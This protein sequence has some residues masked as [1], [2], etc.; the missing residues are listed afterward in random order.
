MTKSIDPSEPTAAEGGSV[1]DL[2]TPVVADAD[3]SADAEITDD[4]EA[5]DLPDAG[6]IAPPRK[7]RHVFAYVLVPLVVMIMA[8]VLGYLRYQE[9]SLQAAQTAAITSVQA[10]T[11]GTVDLL[12]YRPDTVQDTLTAARDRLTGQFRDSY[13]SLTND[14]VIP[15]AKEKNI[16]AT[17][18]VP[19]ASSVTA[20]ENHAV[21]LVF[22]NQSV[23]V[24]ND[25]PSATA[26]A[27][28]V[29]LDKTGDRWLIS[30]FD[31]K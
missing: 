1:R 5:V 30:G 17:A 28:Q 2:D 4:T 9:G 16:S 14:V 20:T 31:P 23:I 21:V 25:A 29:T 7:K 15:G 8:G 12:S 3:E 6:S 19:A 11:D 22:V 10:A 26:S 18:T 27:V 13:T 24:G